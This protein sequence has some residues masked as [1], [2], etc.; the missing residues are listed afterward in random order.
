MSALATLTDA[1]DRALG[2]LRE[3]VVAAYGEPAIGVDPSGEHAVVTITAR[4]A[5]PERVELLPDGTWRRDHLTHTGKAIWHLINYQGR[6]ASV[7]W[8]VAA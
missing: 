5:D 7:I 8:S 1:Q 3:A 4:G 6:P 2:R